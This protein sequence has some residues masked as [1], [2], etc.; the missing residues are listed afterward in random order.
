MTLPEFVD[1]AHRSSRGDRVAHHIFPVILPANVD[2]MRVQRKMREMGVETSVH[3][4]PAHRLA[5]F[6]TEGRTLTLPNTE[7][8]AAR[9]LTLPLFP[10]LTAAQQERVRDSL[11]VALEE[12]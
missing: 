11:E 6:V 7:A 12:A 8:A 5:T 10:S 1:W 2:R 3:Y 9:Q 4:P